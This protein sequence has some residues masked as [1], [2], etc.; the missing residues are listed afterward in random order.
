MTVAYRNLDAVVEERI[1]RFRVRRAEERTADDAVRR[2]FAARVARVAAGGAGVVAGLAMFAKA[3]TAFPGLGTVG[4]GFN[5][6][7][8]IGA[9]VAAGVCG[10]VAWPLARRRARLALQREPLPSGDT[11]ADL[12]EIDAADP[13]GAMRATL[14]G[15]R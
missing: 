4:V 1:E 6:Y 15:G 14:G 10:A 5:T 13:L 9:W 2:V 11:R 7:F 3:G 8:L 12:A